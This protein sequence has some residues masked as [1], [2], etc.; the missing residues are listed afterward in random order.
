MDVH[1]LEVDTII[2]TF[3]NIVQDFRLFPGESGGAGRVEVGF[4][5]PCRSSF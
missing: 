5:V 2:F 3:A 1:A 4:E